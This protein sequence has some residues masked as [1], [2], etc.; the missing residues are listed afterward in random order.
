MN[1]EPVDLPPEPGTLGIGG[2]HEHGID[3]PA[4]P[5]PPNDDADDDDFGSPGDYDDDDGEV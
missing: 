2:E 1:A 3:E 5:M 4:V